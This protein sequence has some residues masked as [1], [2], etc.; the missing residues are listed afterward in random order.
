MRIAS[1]KPNESR[2][3]RMKNL[4]EAGTQTGSVTGNANPN[5]A[6]DFG[7]LREVLRE[8]RTR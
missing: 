1:V 2:E 3:R 5:N 7:P 6:I 8:F 4:I